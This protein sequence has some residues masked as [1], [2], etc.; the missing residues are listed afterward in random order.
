MCC[1]SCTVLVKLS[2]DASCCAYQVIFSNFVSSI[3][4]D[5]SFSCC[6]LTGKS[7]WLGYCTAEC[8]PSEHIC[9]TLQLEK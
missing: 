6:F 9:A 8:K 1:E 4:V 7:V 2:I 3:F 5:P